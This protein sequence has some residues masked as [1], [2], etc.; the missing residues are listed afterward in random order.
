MALVAVAPVAL[1]QGAPLEALRATLTGLRARDGTAPIETYG[2]ELTAAKYQLRDWI[3]PQL[4]SVK[5]EGDEAELARRLNGALGALLAPEDGGDQNFTGLLGEVRVEWKPGLLVVITSVGI[6]CEFDES[7]YGYKNVDGKWQRVW[8]SEQDDYSE[9]HYASQFISDL[10]VWQR[11]ADGRESGP[12]YVLMLSNDVGC[13]SNW[14]PVYYRV[15]RI[16]PTGPKLLIDGSQQWAFHRTGKYLVGSIAQE[17]FPENS[18]VDVI[19]EFSQRSIDGGVHN[20]EGVRHYLIEGDKVRRGAPVALSPR[21]FV[22]EWLTR[23]WT[24]SAGW[25]ASPA[26]ERWHRK[27]IRGEFVHPTMHCQTPDL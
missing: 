4:A 25:S 24:E 2:A 14:H 11:Y 18:P 7:A 12:P 3:E 10:H 6:L 15:W 26:L 17:Y 20:R 8:Q 21:D 13:A 22:D 9:D 27:N 1:A 23:D 19:V 16:D 5:A